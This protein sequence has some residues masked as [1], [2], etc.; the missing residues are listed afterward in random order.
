MRILHSSDW[1]LGR[2]FH[3]VSLLEEQH[4]VLQQFL[5]LARRV[6]PDAVIIAGDLYDRAV[7][8]REAVQLL[9]HVL[10]TLVKDL[11]IPTIAISGNHDSAER[12][13]FA[14]SLL[15]GQRLH[16]VGDALPQQV[17]RLEDEHGPVEVVALPYASP[18]A[19]RSASGDDELR[20]HQAAMQAQV[21][22]A[23]ELLTP[24]V[25]SVA[26]G[27]AFI[28][29]GSESESER[30]LTVGGAGNVS[31]DVFDGF[32]YV[33]LGHLHRPQ[34]IGGSYRV[35]YS[36]S[37]LRYSFS[38]VD[39]TKSVSLVHLDARGQVKVEP[40]HLTPRRQLRVIEG[41]FDQVLEQGR[42]DAHADD[43][44]LVRL[45]DTHLIVDAMARLRTIYPNALH[46]ERPAFQ[47]S[48]AERL[49]PPGQRHDQL[50][51][52]TLFETF[53]EHVTGTAIARQER[54]VVQQTLQ[55]LNV[56]GDA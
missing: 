46:I 11:Q 25:R 24:G 8:P 40:H 50:D 34:S 28:T 26:V 19:V 52:L 20:G 47:G 30:A 36:G 18:E 44:V 23:R 6:Q 13:G 38:E 43:Y 15:S 32:D 41:A 35:H 51:P 2:V 7:P 12:V 3:N 49:L 27:H 39:H 10:T 29:G 31:A 54:Q 4:H 37:L 16:L 55:A 42:S 22:A 5:D 53:Y 21:Q 17:V 45:T 14:S 33:A 56:G 48:A 1:H 9:D